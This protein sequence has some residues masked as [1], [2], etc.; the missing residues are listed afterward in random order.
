MV[1]RIG[2]TTTQEQAQLF[3]KSELWRNYSSQRLP[4]SQRILNFG[5][6]LNCVSGRII[7]L[8]HQ[9]VKI[10]SSHLD[11]QPADHQFLSV[12]RSSATIRA[13]SQRSLQ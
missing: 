5:E 6:S 4:A 8:F 7:C 11:I 9:T 1:A 12:F 13:V 3:L 10:W 2:Q